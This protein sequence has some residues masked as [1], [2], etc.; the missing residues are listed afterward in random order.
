[1]WNVIERKVDKKFEKKRVER[2]EGR[3]KK[4][5]GENEEIA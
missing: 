5:Y 4:G 2:D 3:E 1:V